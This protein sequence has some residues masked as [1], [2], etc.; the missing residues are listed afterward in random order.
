MI[1]LIKNTFYK[2]EETKKALCDFVMGAKQLSMGPQTV[3]FEE[4]FAA[5]HDRKFAVFVNSGSSANLA[6]F[7]AL[8]NL[9]T[10]KSGDKV[11]FSAV[12]WA[13]N[14]MPIIQMGLTPMPVDVE[15]DSLNISRATLEQAYAAEAFQALFITNLLGFCSDIDAIKNFCAEKGILL[16]EDNCESLG[17]VYK[18]TRLGNFGTAST[19]SFFVGHHMSTIEGGMILTDDAELYAML[20]M[21]RAH[22]WNRNLLPAEQT[23]LRETHDIPNFYDRYTFYD[24]AYNLRPTDI[25][26]FIGLTQ[27]PYLDEMIKKRV[28]N[29]NILSKVYKNPDFHP[30][31]V[32]M[33][34][35]SNFAFPVLCTSKEIQGK[36]VARCEEA[37]IELRPIV[38]GSMTEQPF[39][40]KY[41]S[42]V[43][44]L[45]NAKYIHS[46]GFYIGNNPEMTAEDLRSMV[47]ALSH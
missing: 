8:I 22:G 44:P 9:G 11:A 42:T 20:K 30:I 37:G 7:Q 33:D 18:G 28:E 4:V 12:T 26:G 27:L 45:P 3:A 43:H 5:W 1:S 23:G 41:S 15:L 13:T 34:V 14:V 24:L 47:S 29:F 39:Y 2:E 40:K 10:L 25:Q 46:V 16:Y 36:Y 17:S 6:L 35:C 32:S 19:F 38:G 21:V 31:N